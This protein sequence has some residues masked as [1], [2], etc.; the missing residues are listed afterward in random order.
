MHTI[1]IWVLCFPSESSLYFA[2]LDTAAFAWHMRWGTNAILPPACTLNWRRKTHWIPKTKEVRHK[3]HKCH[4][5]MKYVFS[6]LKF[7][8]ESSQTMKLFYLNTWTWKYSNCI[9]PWKVIELGAVT[10]LLFYIFDIFDK[11]KSNSQDC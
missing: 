4:L 11:L 7:Y 5:H 2:H 10:M 6:P 8:M 3:C 9:I 1:L